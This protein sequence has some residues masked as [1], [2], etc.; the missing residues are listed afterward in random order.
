Y[1]RIFRD[2]FNVG[3]SFLMSWFPFEFNI[4]LYKVRENCRPFREAGDE[5]I[6]IVDETVKF[7]NI[8]GRS[9]ILDAR[10]LSTLSCVTS[11]PLEEMMC[12]KKRISSVNNIDLS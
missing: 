10:I 9:G 12:P 8:S 5:L 3:E 2:S 7:F 1:K 6:D 11:T 4:F